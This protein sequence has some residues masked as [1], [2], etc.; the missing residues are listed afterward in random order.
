MARSPHI[1]RR[2]PARSVRLALAAG[3]LSLALATGCLPPTPK[4]V[5]V[6]AVYGSE[7][8][9]HNSPPQPESE[10]YSAS[11]G[12]LRLDAALNETVAFQLALRT[13][14]PPAGP[15]TITLSD[16]VGP[17]DTLAASRAF[18]VYRA[19]YVRREGF[20]SWYAAQVGHATTA[21]L[22][23]DI[24]V[25]W[26]APRGGG[27]LVLSET[28][29]EI[30]W[31]DVHVPLTINPGLY[32]GRLAV[33]RTTSGRPVFA[34]DILLR[35]LPVALPSRRSLPVVCRVDPRDLLAAHLRW[36]ATTAEQLRL[37]PDTPSHFAAL[38]VVN[39]TMRLLQAHRMTPILWASFPKF[40]PVGPRRVE[41]NWEPYDRLVA[42]WLDGTAFADHVRLELW[43]VPVSLEHPNA[44]HNGGLDSPR[45]ARLLAAYLTECRRHFDEQGWLSRAVLRAC[46]PQ[47]LTQAAVDRM[48]RIAAIVRQSETGF[49]IVAHLPPASL[50]GFDWRAA[51]LI[52][53]ADINIWAP[54]AMWFEPQALAREQK[55]GRQSW[56]L[57]DRPPYSGSLAIEAAGTDARILPWIAYRYGLDG[58]WVEHAAKL[59]GT[60]GPGPA[61][62][63]AGLV[64]AGKAY[65]L[66]EIGPVPSVRL[67]RLRRGLE[68]YELLKLLE[69]NGERLLARRMA[70]QIVR[71]AG[72][73]ACLHNLLSTREAG[74][75]ADPAALRLARRLILR[76]LSGRFEPTDATREQ[77]RAASSEWAL[78]FNQAERVTVTIDGVRLVGRP[79]NLRAIVI[80]SVS[81]ATTRPIDGQW[82][83]PPAPLG[84]TLAGN[85]QTIVPPGARRTSRIELQVPALAYNPDGIY[86]FDVE[87]QTTTAGGFPRAARLAVAACPQT[88]RAPR[89][90]GR[91]DDWPLAANNAAGDFRLCRGLRDGS[92]K[93]TLGTRAF[94]RMDDA[95]LYIAVRCV[96]RPDEPP[97]WSADNAIPTDGAI[98]WGQDVVEV[99]IDPRPTVDGTSSD[100]YC[101]QVKPSGLLVTRK[102]ARTNPQMGTSEPW[103]AGARVAVSV[104][105]EAWFVELALPLDAL[106]PAARRERLWGLNVTRLDARRGE[107]SSWSGARSTCYVPQSLGNLILLWP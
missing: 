46:P 103:A 79:E 26:D 82:M 50:R 47:P 45:Y 53:L 77:Q 107:Y 91:L 29:N 15:F 27:P 44:T 6:W 62:I 1:S 3:S 16:L 102:G 42:G 37:L 56:L 89:I 93:P 14:A 13:T 61:S 83:L 55:L 41:V 100:L 48:R 87:F 98:P 31:I 78:M 72:T 36:P 40:R 88:D 105:R 54:P 12:E 49:P 106:G 59:E 43:P 94:F 23:P 86:P 35:V 10:V 19:H 71:W 84:W 11:R 104:E 25:P 80:G 7:P 17:A 66:R 34:C 51:P 75:P 95:R 97:H 39:E 38:R 65:G 92:D 67:K 96:L 22:F 69:A 81:N 21:E 74:W 8:L 2:G 9:T 60:A 30:L 32:R 73:D 99:L 90:D 70:G 101:L 18:S 68:D 33:R 63:G 76:E 24:L 52:D 28:R 58:L 64:Y 57:P 5:T 85:V 4:T 20:R